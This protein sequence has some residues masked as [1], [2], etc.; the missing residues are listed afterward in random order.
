MAVVTVGSGHPLTVAQVAEVADGAALVLADGVLTALRRTRETA[1]AIARQ[2]PV[3]G[4]STGVGANRGVPVADGAHHA[5]RLLVSH[6]TGAG[7]VRDRRR[8]R[9]MLAI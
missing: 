2:R 4:R 3:Y 6:A 1:V 9:A 5:L 7:P 8:V